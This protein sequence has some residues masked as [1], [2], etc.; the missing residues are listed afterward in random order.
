M[1]YFTIRNVP[2][3]KHYDRCANIGL[4][5]NKYP[6]DKDLLK[7]LHPEQFCLRFILKTIHICC[8]KGDTK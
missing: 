6:I 8:T 2:M 3:G 7:F 4:F 1:N 5:H